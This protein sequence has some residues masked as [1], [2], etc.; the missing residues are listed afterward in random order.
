MCVTI[1][2]GSKDE[3]H[4]FLTPE[5]ANALDDYLK[6]REK[7]GEKLKLESPLF[8]ENYKLGIAPAR[9]I[10][11]QALKAVIYQA[12]ISSKIRAK[13]EIKGKRF[14]IAIDHGFRKRFNTILKTT[15]GVKTHIAERLMGHCYNST[16]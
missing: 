12:L 10:Q 5:A 8:R 7:D 3:Y 1:Y 14:D 16:R 15:D 4:T 11:S 6:Q 9:T 2:E 13:S